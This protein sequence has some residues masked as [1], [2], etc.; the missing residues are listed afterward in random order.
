[1]EDEEKLIV[2]LELRNYETETEE[3][4][5][6]GTSIRNKISSEHGITPAVIMI[7]KRGKVYKTTSGKISRSRVKKDYESGLLDQEAVMTITNKSLVEEDKNGI[8]MNE[9]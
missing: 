7:V 2:V 1:M 6:L 5:K 8:I 9:R 4:R 3:L